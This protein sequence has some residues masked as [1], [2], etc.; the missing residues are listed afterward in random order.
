[1]TT[2]TTKKSKRES[3]SGDGNIRQ[4]LQRGAKDKVYAERLAAEVTP[5]GWPFTNP[6]TATTTSSSNGG[7]KKRGRKR[8]SSVTT[9]ATATSGN[10]GGNDN[11]NLKM[12]GSNPDG[13]VSTT[14]TLPPSS[15]SSSCTSTTTALLATTQKRQRRRQTQRSVVVGE[16]SS[17]LPP[18]MLEETLKQQQKKKKE[19]RTS[20]G[21]TPSITTSATPLSSKST[22]TASSRRSN[23]N[24]TN[25]QVNT[26]NKWTCVRCT[27]LNTL[28]RKK[29]QVCGTPRC[30]TN[31]V[32]NGVKVHDDIS[33]SSLVDTVDTVAGNAPNV[34]RVAANRSAENNDDGRKMAATEKGTVEDDD[35]KNASLTLEHS[36]SVSPSRSIPATTTNDSKDDDDDDVN[37]N[38]HDGSL[39][40]TTVNVS[41]T[42]SN[43]RV[44]DAASTTTTGGNEEKIKMANINKGLSAIVP[45]SIFCRGEEQSDDINCDGNP[46]A[47]EESNNVALGETEAAAKV[48]TK[49]EGEECELQQ[50]ESQSQTSIQSELSAMIDASPTSSSSL[51]TPTNLPDSI[52][53]GT[54]PK[55][56]SALTTTNASNDDDDDINSNN[57]DDSLKYTTVNVTMTVS[58]AR[59]YAAAASTTTTGGNQDKIKM[60]N[61]NTVLSAIVPASIFCQGEEQS[62]DINCDGNPVATEESNNV[63]LEETETAAKV[64]TK[65]EGEECELQQEESQSQTSIQSELSAMIDASPTSSSSLSAPT[66]PPDSIQDGT[67]LKEASAA[68]HEESQEEMMIQQQSLSQLSVQSEISAMIDATSLQQKLPGRQQ[69]QELPNPRQDQQEQEQAQQSESGHSTEGCDQIYA[70]DDAVQVPSQQ[71]GQQAQSP[72]DF[73]QWLQKRKNSRREKK[74]R[75]KRSKSTTENDS[76]GQRCIASDGSDGGNDDFGTS[77]KFTTVVV[78]LIVPDRECDDAK[79]TATTTIEDDAASLQNVLLAILP[80]SIFSQKDEKFLGIN[81][82]DAV[83]EVVD[84]ASDNIDDTGDCNHPCSEENDVMQQ[85]SALL[86]EDFIDSAHEDMGGDEQSN[87]HVKESVDIELDAYSAAIVRNRSNNTSEGN[88]DDDTHHQDGIL[89]D[90]NEGNAPI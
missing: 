2:S 8:K 17:P 50:E 13:H 34:L 22:A 63:A 38:N 81:N 10:D 15:L 54:L 19:H 41:L 64:S 30:Y 14:A 11:G 25:K 39:E 18:P 37:S 12:T 89:P 87:F 61:I 31:D 83:E 4:R 84:A 70:N 1:M 77:L 56:A 51:S 36:L 86:C 74:R 75:R 33:S 67:L 7:N 49:E 57:H 21:G 62:D 78:R 55:E 26:N 80:I 66:N 53:D 46:V 69:Q 5:P 40:Y 47:T 16:T 43:A 45:A 28:R 76:E 24:S 6:S 79:A 42:V 32:G 3:S 88:N 82:V 9:T 23:K 73:K 72:S 85:Q 68:N 65:E 48:S 44:Y 58:N 59:V 20:S 29:C 60:A 90:P 27:L 52:E 71:G 35:D